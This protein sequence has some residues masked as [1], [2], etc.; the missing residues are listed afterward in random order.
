MYPT[1]QRWFASLTQ[2]CNVPVYGS[3]ATL[4]LLGACPMAPPD[5]PPA[6]FPKYR[7]VTSDANAE[8]MWPCFSPDSRT[9][10]FSRKTEGERTWNLFSVSLSDGTPSPF[11]PSETP[12]PAT[13]VNWSLSRNVIAFNGRPPQGRFNLSVINANG[14][15]LHQ[16]EF[17]GV[18]DRISYPSWYPDGKSIAVVDFSRDQGSTIKRIDIEKGTIVTLTDRNTHWAGV[19]RVS[20]DGNLI[21]MGGQ[22]REGQRYSQYQNQI[23][24]LDRDGPRPLDSKRGWAPFWSP[25][26]KWITFASD[27]NSDRGLWAIFV[28]SKDGSTVKQLTPHK[29]N[30]A[31][32]TWSPHGKLIAFSGQLSPEKKARGLAVLEVPRELAIND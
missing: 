3:W 22:K 13:R 19:P 29:L 32:P 16:L 30:A 28:A 2:M 4:A 6:R 18:S 21:V 27:R 15:G 23:W 1:K 9:L 25:D 24:F 5:E 26:G 10:V 31:H 8:D 12:L 14:S 11:L 7:F 20:P 17:P